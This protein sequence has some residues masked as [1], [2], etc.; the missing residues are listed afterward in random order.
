MTAVLD[1]QNFAFDNQLV[2]VIMRGLDPWFIAA[3]V[4]AILGIKSA[5]DAVAD[6]DEDEKGVATSDTLGGEQSVV[7][8][9]EPGLYRLIFQSRKPIARPFQRWVMHQVLPAIRKTG[10]YAPEASDYAPEPHAEPKHEPLMHRLQVIRE[11]RAL[12]GRDV[13][14][15]LW[16]RL[17]LPDAPPPPPTALDEARQCLRQL[18]DTPVVS[19]FE[20]SADACR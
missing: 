19:Q 1:L 9:S 2:R 10:K 17:G 5:R 13:A 18:L 12:Y 6:F 11:A 20:I 3:D 14:R 7:V 16:R 8:V 15:L 4:C